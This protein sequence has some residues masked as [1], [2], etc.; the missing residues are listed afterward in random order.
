MSSIKI[1][2]YFQLHL[3]LDF[4]NIFLYNI[5]SSSCITDSGFTEVSSN[6]RVAKSI[7]LTN[8][9]TAAVQRLHVPLCAFKILLHKALR[10]HALLSHDMA[11][12][13]KPIAYHCIDFCRKWH[14]LKHYFFMHTGRCL[15]LNVDIRTMNGTRTFLGRDVDEDCQLEL[16]QLKPPLALPKD[17][18]SHYVHNRNVC[19]V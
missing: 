1:K 3:S 17:S 5:L 8:I 14:R 10:D 6:G 18:E 7:S 11:F 15:A 2:Q 12:S 13:V 4:S 19:A 9:I 16:V